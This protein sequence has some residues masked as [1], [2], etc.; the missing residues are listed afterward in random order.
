MTKKVFIGA[1]V[2]LLLV[3]AVVA[4]GCTTT[5]QPAADAKPKYVMGIDVYA[6]YTF[7][8]DK[9]NPT[10]FDIEAA[11]WVANDQGFDLDFQYIDW[12]AM[13]TY[14][15]TGTRDLIWSG[16]SITDERKAKMDFTDPYW[17]IAIGVAGQK[18]AGLTMDDFYSG[19][20]TIGVQAGCSA[21]EGLADYLG[22]ELYDQMKKDGK[23]KNTYTTFALSMQD[24]LNKRVDFVVFDDVGIK[25]YIKKHED[26]LVFTGTIANTEEE[27]AVAVKKGNAELLKK[28][29][30]G[31][32][33]L[34]KSPDWTALQVKYGFLAAEA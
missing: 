14:L 20:Y 18:D 2:A 29:N 16:L 31:L 22:Q 32:A 5:T 34:K 26:K 7:D 30:T 27:F 24:L 21:D 28:L 1:V 12:D 4:A 25:D 3:F 23:I 11:K 10:G 17:K 33:N 19:K 13:A 8:D 15:E 9:G 6:P